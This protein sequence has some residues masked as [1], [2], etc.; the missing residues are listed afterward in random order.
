MSQQPQAI[1]VMTRYQSQS[2]L[3]SGITHTVPFRVYSM[4]YDY[5]LWWESLQLALPLAQWSVL[6]L[7]SLGWMALLSWG[8]HILVAVFQ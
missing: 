5:R 7:D 3:E 4:C 1:V 2:T 6:R 8:E